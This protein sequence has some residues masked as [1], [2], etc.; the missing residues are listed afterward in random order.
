MGKELTILTYGKSLSMPTVAANA[1]LPLKERERERVRE[2]DIQ[3]T[4]NR[5]IT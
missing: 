3:K 1:V 2:S 4:G 5:S